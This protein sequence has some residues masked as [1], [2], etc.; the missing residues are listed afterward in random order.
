MGTNRWG[1]GWPKDEVS[2]LQ[3]TIDLLR[4]GVQNSFDKVREFHEKFGHPISDEPKVLEPDYELMRLELIREE[5]C[6]LYEACG[7]D[8][9]EL[10]EAKVIKW[11][12]TDIVA[13]ADA[14]GDLEYVVNG[15]AISSGIPLPA[16]VT[17]IHRSNMT[18]LGADGKPIYREDGKVLK[19]PAY[20]EPQ[21][22]DVLGL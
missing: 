18:K 11:D 8:A 4:Y 16:I 19:G 13:V 3:A 2:A 1:R 7:Y 22:M 5:L 15:M 14:L 20:E 6:E 21:L 9:S 12:G 10:I 17:E